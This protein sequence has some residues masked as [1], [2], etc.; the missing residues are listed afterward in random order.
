[1][2]GCTYYVIAAWIWAIIWHMGLDP[3]KVG[4]AGS[5]CLGYW[6]LRMRPGVDGTG[7]EHQLGLRV[8]VLSGLWPGWLDLP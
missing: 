3:I 5:F 8:C 1:M 7:V 4:P 6:Y 2:L